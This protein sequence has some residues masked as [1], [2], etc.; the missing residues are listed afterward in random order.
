MLKALVKS[1]VLPKE[2]LVNWYAVKKVM[3]LKIKIDCD[4]M[5]IVSLVFTGCKLLKK[6]VNGIVRR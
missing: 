4:F 5:Y 3:K 6:R 1:I 2:I